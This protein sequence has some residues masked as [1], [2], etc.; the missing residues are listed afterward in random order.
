[1]RP[2]IQALEDA[3][4]WGVPLPDGTVDALVFVDPGRV[5]GNASAA[6]EELLAGSALGAYVA[7]AR[8]VSPVRGADATPYLDTA[9][10][11]RSAIEPRVTTPPR[12]HDRLDVSDRVE[13]VELPCINGEFVELRT[14]VSHPG[15][16]EPVAYL[17]GC[18]LAPLLRRTSGGSTAGEL[19]RAWSGVV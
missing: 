17:G 7:C 16:D 4:C 10:L 3:W 6:Y 11:C 12:V 19:V 5:G 2:C 14:A 8:R 18:E 15:L 13:Y 1:P 9:C